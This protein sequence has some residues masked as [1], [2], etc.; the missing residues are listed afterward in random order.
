MKDLGRKSSSPTEAPAG[1]P[2][3]HVSYPSLSLEPDQVEGSGLEGKAFGDECELKVKIRVTRIGES[4]GSPGKKK[5]P[6]MGFD[7]VG[8]EA[9]DKEDKKGEK[10]EKHKSVG[11]KIPESKKREVKP[12]EAKIY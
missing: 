2:E 1:K 5:A 6:S 8:I 3:E 11:A 7:I 12:S 9:Y 4:Y 10:E